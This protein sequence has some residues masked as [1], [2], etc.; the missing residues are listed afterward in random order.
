MGQ[1]HGIDAH[2]PLRLAGNLVLY[3]PSCPE[4][5]V[6]LEDGWQ[7]TPDFLRSRFYAMTRTAADCISRHLHQLHRT[8]DCN[9]KAN[10]Y[11]KNT[12]PS[13]YSLANGRAYF[14]QDDEYRALIEKMPQTN[15]VRYKSV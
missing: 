10:R 7:T 13:D 4:E 6:N 11:F 2:L 15:H 1:C 12:D 8:L 9:F 14:P 5:G 3:C